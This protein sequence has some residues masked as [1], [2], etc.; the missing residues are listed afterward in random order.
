[1]GA[2]HVN[3]DKSLHC[4]SRIYLDSAL[5]RDEAPSPSFYFYFFYFN[6]LSTPEC[7]SDETLYKTPR[8]LLR[9]FKC[10]LDCL[11]FDLQCNIGVKANL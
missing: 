3:K 10:I 5:Q 4:M 2:L 9:W 7:V 8:S 1:M 6:N 11:T